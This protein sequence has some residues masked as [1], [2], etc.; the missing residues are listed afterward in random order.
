MCFLSSLLII[1]LCRETCASLRLCSLRLLEPSRSD[2]PSLLQLGSR[3]PCRPFSQAWQ[4]SPVSM[5]STSSPAS[6]RTMTSPFRVQETQA[7]IACL[8]R[9][10]GLDYKGLK[11]VLQHATRSSFG[12]SGPGSSGGLDIH[13]RR[14]EACRSGDPTAASSNLFAL[15]PGKSAKRTHM[16]QTVLASSSMFT[17]FHCQHDNTFM[18]SSGPPFLG[19]CFGLA[20]SAVCSNVHLQLFESRGI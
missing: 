15:S 1:L 14:L 8:T 6:L 4:V 7:G 17:V 12:H 16:R 20:R 9:D 18:G 3:K 13:A 11:R 5:E 19:S 10:L 2:T